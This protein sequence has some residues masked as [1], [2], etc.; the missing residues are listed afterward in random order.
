MATA[1]LSNDNHLE[2]FSLIWLDKEKNIKDIRNT[3]QELRSII[4]YLKKFQYV[5]EC[6][7]YIEQRSEN[8]RLVFIVSGEMG[9]KIVPSIHKLRQVR[10]IY[11]YCMDKKKHKKWTRQF[12][13]V[14][15]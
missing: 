7:R 5:E 11:I 1:V 8:D 6:Q 14:R 12:M 15:F 3:E 13:K 10:S 9:Q 2:I 4:N